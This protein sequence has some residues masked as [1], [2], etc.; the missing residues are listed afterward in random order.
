LDVSDSGL[1]HVGT[2]A[3]VAIIDS[4][5]R[6]EASMALKSLWYY[7]SPNRVVAL[8]LS[9]NAL[10]GWT[11]EPLAKMLQANQALTSLDLSLNLMDDTGGVIIAKAL[12]K[13][14][15]LKTLIFH[16]NKLQF[17]T[18]F[19][20]AKTLRK[21]NTLTHIDLSRNKM[22]PSCYWVDFKTQKKL[23]GAGKALGRAVKYNKSVTSL[24][25]A[26][27]FMG[28]DLGEYRRGY[29]HVAGLL[30][31]NISLKDDDPVVLLPIRN[32]HIGCFAF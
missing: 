23:E 2:D 15:Q 9:G 12:V 3:L 26:E 11:G 5:A 8:N 4:L 29:R 27:N 18:G 22:G 14:K 28:E 32:G 30:Q 19:E 21:N 20:L 17:E 25:L 16:T 10:E 24:N 7:P 1:G 31:V 13:H 6:T